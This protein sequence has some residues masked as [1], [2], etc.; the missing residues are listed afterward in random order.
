MVSSYTELC[1]TLVV[2]KSATRVIRG[3]VS[4]LR[5]L[6]QNQGGSE[7]RTSYL[8]FVDCLSNMIIYEVEDL[9]VCKATCV[10]AKMVVRAV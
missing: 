3:L 7:D 5:T 9:F 10:K 4:C 2:P 8:R 1:C 6:Q